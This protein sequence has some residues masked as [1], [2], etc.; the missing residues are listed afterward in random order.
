MAIKAVSTLVQIETLVS[1]ISTLPRIC[2]LVYIRGW[3]GKIMPWT[4]TVFC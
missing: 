3:L 4:M 2:T 1:D